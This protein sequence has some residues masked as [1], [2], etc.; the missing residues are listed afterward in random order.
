MA[1]FAALAVAFGLLARYGI[2]YET[3]V[4]AIGWITLAWRAGKEM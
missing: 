4:G 1:R 2:N 3:L